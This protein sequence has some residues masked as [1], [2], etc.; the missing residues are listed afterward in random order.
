M[1]FLVAWGIFTFIFTAGTQPISV[2][3]ENTIASE[4]N[5]YLMPTI[6]F[7]EKEGF[8]SG[9]LVKTPA[10]IT[11]VSSN[12]LGQEMG[13]RSGDTVLAINNI[14]VDVRNIG[15]I[16]KQNIGQDITVR[17]MRN[18]SINTAKAHCPADNCIL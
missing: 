18:K 6:T 14:D 13:L 5:S 17:Y 2:L 16:L 4:T 9:E 7:L 8:I 15:T 11:Q 12:L 10:K 1:N 3:P